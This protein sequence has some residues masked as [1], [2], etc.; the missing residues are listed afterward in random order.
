MDTWKLESQVAAEKI[1][2][3]LGRCSR[4]PHFFPQAIYSITCRWSKFKWSSLQGNLPPVSLCK[5][6]CLTIHPRSA[7]ATS[8]SRSSSQ[9]MPR[10]RRSSGVVFEGTV[11]LS[12]GVGGEPKK[13]D[14]YGSPLRQTHSA[15]SERVREDIQTGKCHNH[16]PGLNSFKR[17]ANVKPVVSKK[18]TRHVLS[19]STLGWAEVSA[20]EQA[21]TWSRPGFDVAD[22][23]STDCAFY[24]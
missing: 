5:A 7:R 6:L 18:A 4:S 10:A 1:P 3:G 19:P 15:C 8:G 9:W 22:V 21:H 16:D 11:P 24:Q 2:S 13:N 20:L 12:E 17:W 14:P 23:R